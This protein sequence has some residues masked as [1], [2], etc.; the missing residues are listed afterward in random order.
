VLGQLAGVDL[1]DLHASL[2]WQI[3]ERCVERIPSAVVCRNV[4]Q[5]ACEHGAR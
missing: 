3:G 4:L 2:Q 5:L 1:Q